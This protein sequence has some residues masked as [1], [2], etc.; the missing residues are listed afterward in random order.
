MLT[1]S[2]APRSKTNEPANVG[3]RPPKD[4]RLNRVWED[5]DELMR[6]IKQNKAQL[7][8]HSARMA[9]TLLRKLC[10]NSANVESA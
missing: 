1:L 9:A 5:K 7:T 4:K 10:S 3:L 8:M 6:K 2:E